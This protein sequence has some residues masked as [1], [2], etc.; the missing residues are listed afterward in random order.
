VET[1]A[2]VVRNELD[3]QVLADGCHFE[4]SIYYHVYALDMFLFHAI[5]RGPIMRMP[6]SMPI[7]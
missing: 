6:A 7:S 4:R 1:G 5:L 3:R 2:R